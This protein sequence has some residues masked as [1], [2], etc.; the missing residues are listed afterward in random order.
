MRGMEKLLDFHKN[1]VLI[2]SANTA[3]P[4]ALLFMEKWQ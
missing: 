1:T 2:D 3:A 4:S